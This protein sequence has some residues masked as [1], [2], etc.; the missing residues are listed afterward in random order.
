MELREKMGT[1]YICGKKKVYY[2]RTVHT[3]NSYRTGFSSRG[4]NYSSASQH[5][6]SR[7]VCASCALK[8]DYNNRKEKGIVHGFFVGFTIAILS[9][10][11]LPY[12]LLYTIV[13]IIVGIIIGIGIGVEGY[14]SAKEWYLQNK[15]TYLDEIDLIQEQRNTDNNEKLQQIYSN[16]EVMLES[17]KAGNDLLKTKV[18]VIV[19]KFQTFEVSS[20]AEC[21]EYL[22]EV[23]QY[24][25]EIIKAKESILKTYEECTELSKQYHISNEQLTD[26]V[27]SE[28]ICISEYTNASNTV[29]TFLKDVENQLLQA[30]IKL[31]Q[32]QKNP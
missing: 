16:K 25:K 22:N 2:R 6:G 3:G 27:E 11:L 9:M 5:Y 13:T 12:S 18:D 14:K 32:E 1:C 19:K 31:L 29:I 17:F 15:N 24:E 20:I 4:T 23:H 8:I 30:K 28:R 10:F 21:D 7:I 26:I